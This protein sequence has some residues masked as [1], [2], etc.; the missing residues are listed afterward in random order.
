MLPS[1]V[2]IAAANIHLFRRISGIVKRPIG[3]LI[4][5]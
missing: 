2:V 5:I 1:G 4:R 3:S